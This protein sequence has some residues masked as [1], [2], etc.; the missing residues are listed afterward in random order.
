MKTSPA[1][2][3]IVDRCTSMAN[4]AAVQQAEK[5]ANG[6]DRFL[7]IDEPNRQK[8]SHKLTRVP[9]QVSRLMESCSLR[10]H[11]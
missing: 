7:Q 1:Q 4:S 9:F 5:R 11:N 6:G 2:Q 8:Q 10:E 3:T